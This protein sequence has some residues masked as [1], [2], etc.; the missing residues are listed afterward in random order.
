MTLPARYDDRTVKPLN[1]QGGP[2][3]RAVLLMFMFTSICH[4]ISV[5][6]FMTLFHHIQTF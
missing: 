4:H 6:F 1:L 3:H 5:F 2:K